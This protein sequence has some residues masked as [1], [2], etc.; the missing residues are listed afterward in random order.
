ME[1]DK[2]TTASVKYPYVSFATFGS[3]LVALADLGIPPTIDRSVLSQF[4]GANKGLLLQVFRHLGLTNSKDESQEVFLAYAK[5][6]PEKRKA[7][8][9]GLLKQHYPEQ[10]KV[11]ATGTIQNLKDT[12]NN[13]SVEASVK[14]KCITF[15][16]QTA[17]ESGLP[18]SGHILKGARGTRGPRKE[19]TKKS[20]NGKSNT[21]PRDA[22]D[23]DDSSMD[24]IKLQKGMAR[25]R[26]A[27]GINKE[28]AISMP[29]NYTKDELERFLKVV[30][31]TLDK[32]K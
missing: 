31:I 26:I 4:S 23:G 14:S 24:E 7:I 17:K 32:P 28:W 25:V 1:K 13:T 30:Q 22:A 12:F 20:K 6:D 5:A 9:A 3:A 21:S 29:E 27:V 15:F 11:L 16:L 18:I 10:M 8:L 19:G 2:P